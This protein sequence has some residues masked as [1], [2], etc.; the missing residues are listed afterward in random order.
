MNQTLHFIDY[1]IDN[2]LFRAYRDS[3]GRLVFVLDYFTNEIKPNVL[4]V[5]N[6]DGDRKWDDIISNDYNI[7]LEDIRPKKDNKYQ[8]L[9]IEYSGLNIYDELFATY[10]A[11]EDTSDALAQLE[12]AQ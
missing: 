5:I 12:N 7:D 9:D 11:Q 1:T 10:N 2:N 3:N 6:P 8:K 4:L